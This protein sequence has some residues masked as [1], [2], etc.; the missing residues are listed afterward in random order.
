[1]ESPAQIWKRVERWNGLE[2]DTQK[3]EGASR[4]SERCIWHSAIQS[5]TA[6]TK[7]DFQEP[8]R[9]VT[10]VVA[11]SDLTLC[12]YRSSVCGERCTRRKYQVDAVI[13]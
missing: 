4:R 6:G 8:K 10:A 5:R 2:T 9:L 13:G 7:R 1:M 12:R 3:K 11:R